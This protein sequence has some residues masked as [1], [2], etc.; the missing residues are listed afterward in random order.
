MVTS[1]CLSG[2]SYSWSESAGRRFCSTALVRW[3]SGNGRANGESDRSEALAGHE[4]KPLL[5][6]W[7][8]ERERGVTHG[9]YIQTSDSYIMTE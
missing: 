1:L 4:H 5:C 6:G 8:R 9:G 3:A 7:Q 2:E